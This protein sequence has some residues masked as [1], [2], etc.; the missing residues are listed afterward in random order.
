MRLVGLSILMPCLVV[1]GAGCTVPGLTTD[2]NVTDANDCETPL[3]RGACEMSELVGS[4]SVVHED[5]YSVISGQVADGVVPATIL[6]KVG[7]N[8]DCV[9]LRQISPFCDPSCPSGTTCDFDGTCIPYPEP[10]SVGM[11]TV[12]GLNK[13]V[14]MEPTAPSDTYFDT[15]L[16]HPAFDPG[17]CIELVAEGA[18]IAGFTLYGTGVTPLEMPS[19]PWVMRYGQPLQISWVPA[20]DPQAR[21]LLTLNIDQHGLSPVTLVCDVEDTGSFAVPAEMISALMDFGFT[22]LAKGDIYRQTVDSVQT[23]HGCVEFKVV[24]HLEADLQVEE[25]TP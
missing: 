14:A 7:E 5:G 21:I 16:P 18:D 9:L 1:L 19:D 22:G 20:D 10:I 6:Q 4:F 23:V 2:P 12:K 11:V 3:L 13:S 24:S 15:Q 17:A 8:G 25:G